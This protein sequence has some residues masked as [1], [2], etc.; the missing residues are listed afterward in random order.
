MLVFTCTHNA[1][2]NA[3]CTP[4]QIDLSVDYMSLYSLVQIL[5][6]QKNVIWINDFNRKGLASSAKKY[7]HELK[8]L[9][10]GIKA[11]LCVSF[12]NEARND[13]W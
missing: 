2:T 6:P 5:H 9:V 1:N 10:L 12:Q 8:T 11:C 3:Q 13:H 4:F 7:V